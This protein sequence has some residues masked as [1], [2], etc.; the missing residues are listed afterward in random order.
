MQSTFDVHYTLAIAS[1]YLTSRKSQ[2]LSVI[3][4]IA[5]LGVALGVGAFL[6]VLAITTGFEEE[7]RRKLLGANAHVLIMKYGDFEEYRDVV[8]RLEAMPE[9]VGAGPFRL[10]PMMM[11]HGD[12]IA[13]VLFKG[14]DPETAEKVLSLPHQVVAG[15]MGSLRQL[16]SESVS[17]GGDEAPNELDAY[18]QAVE[19]AWSQG[20]SEPL[21]PDSIAPKTDASSLQGSPI[22][23][24]Q[25]AVPSPQ[26][27]ER[28]LAKAP[29]VPSMPWTEESIRM[30]ED[31]PRDSQDPLPVLC[32]GSTLAQ[33]LALNVGDRVHVIS[34]I[35][36]WGGLASPRQSPRSREFEVGCIFN[37]GFDE[38]DS[39]LVL[40]HLKEV[41]K[42]VDRG[43]VVD[44]I[45]VRLVDAQ[46]AKAFARSIEREL[47]E[48]S[49][50]TMDW[51]ALNHNLFTALAI[52]K[53]MLSL[54][55]ASIV[56]VAAFT[57]VATL[58]V[59]VLE[60]KREI[61]ILKAMGARYL[62]ISLIFLVQGMVIAGIGM[63]IGMGAGLGV[64]WYLDHI[65]FPLDPRV[66]LIDHLPV[67]LSG[68]ELWITTVVAFVISL[69]ATWIPSWWAARLI[70]AEAMR[71][72]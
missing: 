40:A 14:I 33:E 47:G 71:K 69:V 3:T 42:L 10:H 32:V 53:I 68:E 66:Y 52:Q 70:P 63:V 9:V 24:P 39:E 26:D 67:H 2:S 22:E 35:S 30:L 56:F 17:G 25:V 8:K 45:E 64:V 44:G 51:Q 7:F 29:S 59:S 57:V 23:I 31:S 28:A 12:R 65:R 41:Q 60:R 48:G 34:P 4:W 37:A 58:I 18:L 43:D 38:Y 20:R 19:R 49:Y 21:P 50:H 72:E 13:G 61:A 16:A 55:I 1:R 15:D 27:A 46:I 6:S 54:V 36:T 62:H 5:V 11:I